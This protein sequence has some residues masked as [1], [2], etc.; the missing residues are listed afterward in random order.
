MPKP[1]I[2]LIQRSEITNFGNHLEIKN[3]RGKDMLI[4]VSEELFND[5]KNACNEIIKRIDGG[6]ISNKDLIVTE[7]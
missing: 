3:I 1:N 7:P 2:E 5:F 4:L 6:K